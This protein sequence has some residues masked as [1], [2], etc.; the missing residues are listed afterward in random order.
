M[1]IDRLT[2]IVFLSIHFETL[3]SVRVKHTNPFG[4]LSVKTIRIESVRIYTRRLCDNQETY[5]C[6]TRNRAD[7]EINVYTKFFYCLLLHCYLWQ[8]CF[9]FFALALMIPNRRHSMPRTFSAGFRS[10][11]HNTLYT[12]ICVHG[13]PPP[14]DGYLLSVSFSGQY[15]RRDKNNNI[16]TKIIGPAIMEM[17]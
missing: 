17:A 8:K 1:V 16:M 9:G 3:D 14:A 13:N 4:D 15:H 2:A 6:V 7:F 10:S 12:C 11:S 5:W